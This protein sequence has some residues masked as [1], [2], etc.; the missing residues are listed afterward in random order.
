MRP[1]V[2]KLH[3]ALKHAGYSAL[4]ILPGESAAEFEKLHR[5]LIAAYNPNGADEDAI[6]AK[7]ARVL[8]RSQNLETFRIAELARA[9]CEQIRREKIPQGEPLYPFPVLAS[10]TPVDPAKREAGIRAAEEQ[11]RK[12]LGEINELVELGELATVDRLI[13]DLEVQER[14]D[15]VFDRCVKRLL[16]VKGL[17]SISNVSSSAPPKRLA[18]PSKA[19]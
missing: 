17:K 9:R 7:M 6:V 12:E 15:A 16:M 18:G 10:F 3:P 13:K 19:A 1:N 14:L 11:I 2:K 5:D 8:W 4:S